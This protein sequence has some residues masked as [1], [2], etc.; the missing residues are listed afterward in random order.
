PEQRLAVSGEMVRLARQAREGELVMIGSFWR[1]CD[2]LEAGD[3]EASDAQIAACQALVDALRQPVWQWYAALVRS[4]RAML[5]GRFDEAEQAAGQALALGQRAHG[6]T[7][8]QTYG[9][10]LL[11][12]RREQ[13]R[14]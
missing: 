6:T 13:G 7:A 9:G 5:A 1:L 3:I 12:V 8:L 10:Q 4:M 14:L 2:L 11:V